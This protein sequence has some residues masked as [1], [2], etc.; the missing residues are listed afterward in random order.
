MLQMSIEYTGLDEVIATLRGF[1][2]QIVQAAGEALLEGM[3]PLVTELATYPDRVSNYVRTGA[4]GLGYTTFGVQITPY[5]TSVKGTTDNPDIDYAKWV[6]GIPDGRG[7]AWMHLG[8]WADITYVRDSFVAF[9]IMG[10]IQQRMDDLG[11]ELF[12]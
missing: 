6:R 4:Y 8:Y 5:E 2:Y 12:A 9:T 10:K 1:N 3:S 7:P 11:S